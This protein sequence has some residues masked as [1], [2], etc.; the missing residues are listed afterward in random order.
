MGQVGLR[1]KSP[2]A[3]STLQSD[4]ST[5]QSDWERRPARYRVHEQPKPGRNAAPARDK[6]GHHNHS[7]P[8][9][10]WPNTQRQRWTVPVA[11][12][13]HGRMKANIFSY[14]AAQRVVVN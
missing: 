9:P 12:K 10:G 8:S 7:C 1:S 6:P 2:D 14:F 11:T 5:P 4:E 13:M 3:Q